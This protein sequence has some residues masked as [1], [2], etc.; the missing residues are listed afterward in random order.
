MVELIALEVN[1]CTFAMCR[2]AFGIIKRAFTA[3]IMAEIILQLLLKLRIVLCLFISALNLEDQRHQRLGN[4]APTVN[5][6]MPL[7]VG[8]CKIGFHEAAF[9]N[10]AISAAS[11]TPGAD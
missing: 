5:T 3:N 11:F 4:V 1:L 2:Q 9:T 10:A 8:P 6:E 7:A